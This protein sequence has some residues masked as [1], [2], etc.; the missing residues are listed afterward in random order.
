MYYSKLKVKFTDQGEVSQRELGCNER[1]QLSGLSDNI[2]LLFLNNRT[3]MAYAL[4]VYIKQMSITFIY[5]FK[6]F[7]PFH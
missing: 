6:F 1:V 5:N 3:L 2:K 7:T 4:I